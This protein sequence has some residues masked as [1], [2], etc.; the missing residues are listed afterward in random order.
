M[1]SES[2]WLDLL[3]NEQHLIDVLLADEPLPSFPGDADSQGGRLYKTLDVVRLLMRCEYEE[4]AR[5]IKA[6]SDGS[7]S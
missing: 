4:A 7:Q 1:R 3:D 2:K 5:Q 6:I